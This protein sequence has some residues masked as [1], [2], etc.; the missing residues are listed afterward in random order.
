[1]EGYLEWCAAGGMLKGEVRL[2]PVVHL[3]VA[4]FLIGAAILAH[5]QQAGGVDGIII[6]VIVNVEV[7]R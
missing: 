4:G 3:D 1:M 5:C 6:R 2:H 7:G